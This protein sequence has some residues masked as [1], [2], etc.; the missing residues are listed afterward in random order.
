MANGKHWTVVARPNE[1]AGRLGN[2]SHR[3]SLIM[4]PNS[5]INS[6]TPD[7]GVVYSED[8]LYENIGT[9]LTDGVVEGNDLFEDPVN[10]DY[11][12]VVD[13]ETVVIGNE[14]TK[15]A[16][17]YAPNIKSPSIQGDWSSQEVTDD[18]IELLKQIGEKSDTPFTSPPGTTE[19]NPIA[20][21]KRTTELIARQTIGSLRKGTSTPGSATGT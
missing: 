6:A 18:V 10:R 15:L 20:N 19:T 14:E 7:S 3:N 5:P 16:S 11:V 1:G 8:Y 9:W 4:F 12:N 21:P 17:A 13:L 2:S